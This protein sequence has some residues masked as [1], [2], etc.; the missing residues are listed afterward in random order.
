MHVSKLKYIH[1][2]MIDHDTGE[3]MYLNFYGTWTRNPSNE[4]NSASIVETRAR[5]SKSLKLYNDRF[6]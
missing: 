5:P 4:K 3:V 6:P 1:V 2:Y